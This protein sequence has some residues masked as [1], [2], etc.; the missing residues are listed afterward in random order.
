MRPHTW[1]KPKP[2]MPIAGKTVL[3][4]VLD[5]FDSIPAA[6]EKEFVFIVGHQGEQIENTCRTIIPM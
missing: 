1:S 2:L 3:D 6:F 4:Y 5:Q